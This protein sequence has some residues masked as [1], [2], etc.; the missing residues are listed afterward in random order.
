MRRATACAL[1]E[2]RGGGGVT[3]H[4]RPDALPPLPGIPSRDS[5]SAEVVKMTGFSLRVCGALEEE[6][7][8]T[9]PV[10]LRRRGQM[11]SLLRDHSFE[12][13][14]HRSIKDCS[15]CTHVNR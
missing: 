10:S 3:R 13:T 11:H 4:S 7:P 8:A 5:V 1:E 6:V 9:R 15:Y 14:E 12:C 2:M